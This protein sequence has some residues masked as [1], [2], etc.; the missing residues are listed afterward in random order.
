MKCCDMSVAML[1]EP[2]QLQRQVVESI[3]GGANTITYQTYAHTKAF[4][5]PLSG[6]EVMY[7]ERL[8]SQ[9]RNRMTIRY[10]PDVKDSDRV[11]IRGRA[12]Q[13]RFMNNLEFR[14]RWLVLDLDG[15]VA[16]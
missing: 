10:R 8:D 4:M 6:N 15:G 11:L 9:T 14:N 16:T 2:V 5:N 13:V 12:Y 3:G 1:R 7:A